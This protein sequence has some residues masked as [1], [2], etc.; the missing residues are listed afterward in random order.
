MV[1]AVF[2]F[3]LDGSTPSAVTD[4]KGAD[5]AAVRILPT[6]LRYSSPLEYV[7]G[8]INGTRPPLH[9]VPGLVERCPA[10]YDASIERRAHYLD[11]RTMYAVL[12]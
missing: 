1:P 3:L 5:G 8:H 7:R 2:D 4:Y 6:P 9:R 11:P 10:K 12:R